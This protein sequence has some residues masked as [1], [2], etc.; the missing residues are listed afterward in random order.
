MFLGLCCCVHQLLEL[1]TSKCKDT[2]LNSLSSYISASHWLQM[3][4][5][6]VL[7]WE[8]VNINFRINHWHFFLYYI[9]KRRDP[10]LLYKLV[11][12]LPFAW[13]PKDPSF[14]RMVVQQKKMPCL[15]FSPHNNTYKSRRNIQIWVSPWV[16]NWYSIFADQQ[17]LFRWIPPYSV[18]DK[19]NWAELQLILI[20]RTFQLYCYCPSWC[21]NLAISVNC[22]IF[23]AA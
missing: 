23:C 18:L 15:R 6:L 9:D 3:R 21:H 4:K 22:F 13:W 5:K 20:K 16:S 17:D 7:G 12:F 2:I 8:P 1:L 10:E 19:F 14:Q 11:I